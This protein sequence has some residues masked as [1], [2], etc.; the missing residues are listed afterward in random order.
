MTAQ[1]GAERMMKQFGCVVISLVPDETDKLAPGD[2]LRKYAGHR[3]DWGSELEVTGPSTREER[4]EQARALFG[5]NF[6]EPNANREGIRYFQCRLVRQ[7]LGAILKR[8]EV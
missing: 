1:Q 7:N 5:P 2:R 8:E 3:L 6:I 4:A